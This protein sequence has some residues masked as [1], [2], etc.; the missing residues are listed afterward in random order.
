M[1]RLETTLREI[2]RP[3]RKNAGFGMTQLRDSQMEPA[4]VTLVTF[5]IPIRDI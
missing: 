3:A 5:V 2:P 4:R 1:A